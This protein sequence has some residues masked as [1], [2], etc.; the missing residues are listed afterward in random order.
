MYVAKRELR[1]D[2]EGDVRNGENRSLLRWP[3][4]VV[5]RILPIF[6]PPTHAAG[7][8]LANCMIVAARISIVLRSVFPMVTDI[9]TIL[10]A[11]LFPLGLPVFTSSNSWRGEIRRKTFRQAS[12]TGLWDGSDSLSVLRP[13]SGFG[14]LSCR[15][16]LV[17]TLAPADS[18]LPQKLR[19]IPPIVL[20]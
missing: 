19:T 5:V 7:V 10:I 8:P 11:R 20:L 13:P 9:F 14:P 12:R 18:L 4:L 1:T 16:I 6:L 17:G 15:I 3:A 2:D